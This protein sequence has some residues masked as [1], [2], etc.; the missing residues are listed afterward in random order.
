MLIRRIEKLRDYARTEE[1]RWL[2][3]GVNR[4][5]GMAQPEEET[6][7]QV[8]EEPS[9]PVQPPIP[10]GLP[11]SPEERWPWLKPKDK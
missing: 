1:Y 8:R 3:T 11:K 10:E 5:V 7:V 6:R 4:N 9:A 2:Q